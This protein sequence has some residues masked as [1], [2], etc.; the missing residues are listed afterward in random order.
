VRGRRIFHRIV[1]KVSLD[2][3]PLI[4]V[5]KSAGEI[6]TD[7]I[8]KLTMS[9]TTSASNVMKKGLRMKK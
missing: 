9:I 1:R 3:D 8:A 7:P 6:N 4:T 2:D 5:H